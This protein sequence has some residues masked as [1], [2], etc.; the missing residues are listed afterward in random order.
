MPAASA[1]VSTIAAVLDRRLA[2][3]SGRPLA[4]ALS[5]G[6]DS[7]ALLLAARL[8]AG[9]RRAL[10]VLS[11]DHRLQAAGADWTAAC[12]A[13][14]ERLGLPFTALAWAGAKPTTGIPAAARAARHALLAEAARGIGAGVIL[15]GHTADDILEARAMRAGGSTTPEP[16]EWAPSPAWPEGRDV[17]ILRPMLSLR[18][19]AIRDWLTAQGESWIDDPANEDLRYARARAR[20][21]PLAAAAPCPPAQTRET[22]DL[23]R[24]TGTDLAGSL[25]VA[26]DLLRAASPLAARAFVGAACLCAAGGKRPPNSARLDR[27]VAALRS[28][29]RVGAT[30]AGARVAADDTVRFC[31]E[32]GREGLA[33]QSGDIPVWDGR[34][35]IVRSP[36]LTIRAL[37]GVSKRLGEED[38]RAIA[39]IRSEARGALPVA[40]NSEGEVRLAAARAL[41][42]PRLL[43]ACGAVSE[44]RRHPTE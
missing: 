40:V 12:A 35:E 28:R 3:E 34:F 22:A 20:A 4:V 6:G 38:R 43:A 37:A 14:A 30:L 42:L 13:T 25:F 9:T 10:H 33:T 18:R 11:V 15:M 1:L 44:E 31:R 24:A 39:G 21:G 17:F 23:A 36:D 16:R 41:A 2:R 29:E 32:P 8:W 19:A 7:L 27:L 5:G 26:R